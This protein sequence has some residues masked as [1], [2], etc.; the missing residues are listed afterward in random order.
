MCCMDKKKIL[1]LLLCVIF[2]LMLTVRPTLADDG[3]GG[4]KNNPLVLNSSSPSDG[5]KDVPVQTEIS[6]NFSKNV[7]HMTVR[8]ENKKCFSLLDANGKSVPV[9]IIMADDQVEPEKRRDVCL[10][11][12]QDLEPGAVY[13]V[14]VAPSFQSKSEVTL[15]EELK[16]SFTT[17]EKNSSGGSSKGES[18]DAGK[19]GAGQKAAASQQGPSDTTV[20]S[21]A[22]QGK[23]DASQAVTGSTDIQEQT[24][25]Q[26]DLP[27]NE[28]V[29]TAGSN[30]QDTALNNDTMEEQAPQVS[31]G[32][33]SFSKIS[34]LLLLAALIGFTLYRLL[35]AK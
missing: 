25:V 14:K 34:I 21:P 8:D 16:I 28:A 35:R 15:G 23:E 2:A 1:P 17:A 11:P 19:V 24:P 22:L 31:K 5:A 20:S 18:G 4:K 27:D 9:D 26:D 6:L 3:S 32:S 29:E 10:K 7:V 33:I 13:T 12:L 30:A